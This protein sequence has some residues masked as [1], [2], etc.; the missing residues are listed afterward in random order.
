MSVAN[1][2]PSSPTDT[3]VRISG[4]ILTAQW[5]ADGYGYVEHSVALGTQVR[6]DEVADE[7]ARFGI[8]LVP[9]DEDQPYYT[10][11]ST[12]CFCIRPIVPML[13]LLVAA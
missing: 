12:V 7:L 9:A 6:W 10:D 4:G 3:T 5:D 11:A 1:L 13:R 2:F 8:E